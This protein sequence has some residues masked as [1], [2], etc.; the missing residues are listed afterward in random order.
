MA[1]SVNTDLYCL[2]SEVVFNLKTYS[3]RQFENDDDFDSF[4]RVSLDFGNEKGRQSS[5]GD[6]DI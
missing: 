3:Y 6:Y 5:K 2:C 4:R 1:L